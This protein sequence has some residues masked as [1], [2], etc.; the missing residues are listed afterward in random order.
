MD[1]HAAAGDREAGGGA[2]MTVIVEAAGYRQYWQ[3]DS[4]GVWLSIWTTM[5][6]AT[7][8]GAEPRW[9]LLPPRAE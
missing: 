5:D 9:A 2:V 7:R 8:R 6:M 4:A 3:Q 1:K